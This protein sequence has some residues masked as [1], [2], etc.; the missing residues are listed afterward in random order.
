MLRVGVYPADR[1]GC[2]HYRLIWPALAVRAVYGDVLDVKLGSELDPIIVAHTEPL[3]EGEKE[4]LEYNVPVHVESTPDLDVM[5]FQR[6]LHAKWKHVFPLLR[7]RGIT[8]IVDLDDH[9]DRIDYR[10][11]AW[12]AAEPH[13]MSTQ[14]ATRVRD[15]YG[16][17][18]V[19]RM[20]ADAKWIRTLDHLGCANRVHLNEALRHADLITTSSTELCSYYSRFAPTLLLRNAVPAEYIALSERVSRDQRNVVVGWTGSVLTHPGDLDVIG[21][22]VRQA[23]SRV[24][25]TLKIVGTGHGVARALG[26]APDTTTGWVDIAVYAKEYATFDVA[27]CPLR[28]T[29]FNRAKSWLKPLEAAA[30]GAVPIMSPLPEYIELHERYGVGLIAQRPRDWA[31]HITH[32]VSDEAF[33]C[34]MKKRGYH[35]ASQHTYTARAGEWAKGWAEAWERANMLS[36]PRS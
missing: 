33:R 13:W 12:H 2:G 24:D 11:I 19:D 20:S 4:P 18:R 6:P 14:E 23:R 30:V 27:L 7:Q 32:L 8:V 26:V 21:F 31:R 28:S 25:F 17:F 3:G 22:G 9:F 10:N 15:T 16:T 5:V 34:E 35:A 1:G 36:Q 29:P